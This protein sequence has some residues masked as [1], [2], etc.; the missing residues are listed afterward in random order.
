[1]E[2]FETSSLTGFNIEE[3]FS[4]CSTSILSKIANSEIDPKPQYLIKIISN[5]IL[6]LARE[7]KLQRD[8]NL[9]FFLDVEIKKKYQKGFHFI[10]RKI[11]VFKIMENFFLKS[12]LI[13][14]K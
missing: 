7:I 6:V 1:M 2:Y 11:F 12:M 4:F 8:I 14:N 10:Q 9:L 13:F 5:Y 3:L